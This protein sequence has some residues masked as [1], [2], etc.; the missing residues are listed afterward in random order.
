MTSPFEKLA[1]ELET[2]IQSAYTDGVTV[3]Q[4]EKLAA[5]FLHAQMQ[6]SEALRVADL[7]ARMRKSGLKAVRAT[8]YLEGATKGDKKP[9]DVLLQAQVDTHEVVQ[10]EADAYEKAEVDKDNIERYYNIAREG[11][12]YFRA[13]AK[14]GF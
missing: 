3:D 1:K 12:I 10:T 5:R 9:S 11:H 14:G 8:V 2:H 4:A 13:L 6:L 7:D